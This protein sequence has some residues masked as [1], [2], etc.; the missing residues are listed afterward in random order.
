MNSTTLKSQ[1]E[2]VKEVNPGKIRKEIVKGAYKGKQKIG[3]PHCDLRIDLP[4][5]NKSGVPY[6]TYSTRNWQHVS[7]IQFDEM[8]D[9]KKRGNCIC[10]FF[11]VLP[12]TIDCCTVNYQKHLNQ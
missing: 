3:E 1:F 8:H 12:D 10:H 7:R 2:H 4:W 9:V 11:V 5:Y 6:K